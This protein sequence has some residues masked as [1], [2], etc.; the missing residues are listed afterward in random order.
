MSSPQ[1]AVK[2]LD[3]EFVPYITAEQIAARIRELGAQVQEDLCTLNPVFLAVLNGSFFFVA[4]LL[5]EIDL[6]CEISFVKVRSYEGLQ[7]SGTMNTLIGLDESLKGR[8]VVIVEDIVD[9]G[10]TMSHLVQELQNLGVAGIR[11]ATLILK[12][13]ALKFDVPLDYVGFETPNAFIIGYGLDY[14]K[15]G[16]HYKDILILK[17]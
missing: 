15:Q 6:P 13:E 2:V 8:H 7:S 4:D 5:K 12:R 11:V 3:K 17:D 14:N 10:R 16:R 1:R 9:T